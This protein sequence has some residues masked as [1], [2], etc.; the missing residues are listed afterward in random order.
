MTAH[1]PFVLME[2]I[3]SCITNEKLVQPRV[4]TKYE[5]DWTISLLL[6]V[7]PIEN[8]LVISHTHFSAPNLQDV[9]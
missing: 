2:H 1:S 9:S 3:C 5:N 8:Q 6:L 4:E 7:F